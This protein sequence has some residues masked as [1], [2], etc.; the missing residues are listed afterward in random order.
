MYTV[1]QIA[2]FITTSFGVRS[3]TMQRWDGLP[4]GVESLREVSC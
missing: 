4:D 3:L 1:L 2:T